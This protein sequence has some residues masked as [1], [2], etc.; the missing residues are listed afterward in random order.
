MQKRLTRPLSQTVFLT[1]IFLLSGCWNGDSG[2]RFG[3]HSLGDQLIDLKRAM[4]EGAI[5]ENEFEQTKTNLLGM[6][7]QCEALSTE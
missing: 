3:D 4:D 1:L 5:T 6:V 2:I 7:N